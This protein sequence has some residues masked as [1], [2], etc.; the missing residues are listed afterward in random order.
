MIGG[1]VYD[2]VDNISMGEEL[3]FLYRGQ[4]FFLQGYN[5][6]GT[7]NLYLDRW[8]PPGDDYIWVGK[9]S[10][11]KGYPVEDFLQQRLWDGRTFWDAQDEME[12]VDC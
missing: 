10:M 4:K 8:E 1:S 2:F 7:P 9:G 12:W 5:S 11:A 6:E 3:V